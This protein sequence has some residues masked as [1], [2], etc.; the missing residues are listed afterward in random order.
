MH[1]CEAVEDE[2]VDFLGFLR[3]EGE[4]WQW[5]ACFFGSDNIS[6]MPGVLLAVYSLFA[7]VFVRLCFSVCA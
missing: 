3:C 5:R 2:C 6:C 4:C 1:A 7:D